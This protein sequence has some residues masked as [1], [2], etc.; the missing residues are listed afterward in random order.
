MTG[1]VTSYLHAITQIYAT[2]IVLQLPE[3]LEFLFLFIF[4]QLMGYE[5]W[6]GKP[7]MKRDKSR[8]VAATKPNVYHIFNGP[9][10]V[11]G[12]DGCKN[13]TQQT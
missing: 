4:K 12:R 6:P 7:E 13:L 11:Q 8:T 10:Y 5:N 9:L 1:D 2:T 3:I